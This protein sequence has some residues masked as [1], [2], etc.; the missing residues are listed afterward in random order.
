MID[1]YL[2]LVSMG[3][4]QCQCEFPSVTEKILV[5]WHGRNGFAKV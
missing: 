5:D 3:A 2:D 1:F 4:G